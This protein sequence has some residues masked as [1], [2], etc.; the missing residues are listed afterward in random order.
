[1]RIGS[2]SVLQRLFE[3]ACLGAELA[4]EE[5]NIPGSDRRHILVK[6]SDKVPLGCNN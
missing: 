2:S 1:M 5:V 6:L 3:C 4:F